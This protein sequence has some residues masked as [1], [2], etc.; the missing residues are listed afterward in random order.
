MH[1]WLSVLVTL[2]LCSLTQW[3]G[4]LPRVAISVFS[5]LYVCCGCSIP[6]P[7]SLR[8]A[9][10]PTTPPL[11]LLLVTITTRSDLFSFADDD[12][13]LSLSLGHGMCHHE[14]EFLRLVDARSMSLC[15]SASKP[16]RDS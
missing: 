5:L 7:V 11:F 4:S 1:G 12:L 14:Q 8:F 2:C 9:F 6:F 3:M 16:E 13:P 15:T 10:M